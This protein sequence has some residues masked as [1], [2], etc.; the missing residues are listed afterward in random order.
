MYVIQ[1]IVIGGMDSYI[2]FGTLQYFM[3]SY[4]VKL[5]THTQHIHITHTHIKL[6]N[7]QS[8]AKNNK[9]NNNNNAKRNYE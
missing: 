6:R 8:Y 7:D 4:V 2:C 9:N 5:C 3:D 1:T